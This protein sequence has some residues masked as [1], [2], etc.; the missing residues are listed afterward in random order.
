M[1]EAIATWRNVSLMP[2]ATPLIRSGT[3]ESATFAST[4]LTRP[5]PRPPTMKPGSNT[6]HGSSGLAPLIRARPIPVIAEPGREQIA[7]RD[8]P[9]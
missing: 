8:L 3:V 7:R 5:T 4:G 6:V 9:L 2:D 1:P